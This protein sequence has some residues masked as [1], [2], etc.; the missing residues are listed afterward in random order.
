MIFTPITFLRSV[1]TERN[2]DAV[3]ILASVEDMAATT[4]NSSRENANFIARTEI[5]CLDDMSLNDELAKD[6]D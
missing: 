3:D 6:V 5:N 2:F 4:R 1:C